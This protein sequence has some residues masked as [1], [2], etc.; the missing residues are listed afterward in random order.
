MCSSHDRP[1]RSHSMQHR[2]PAHEK[3][4]P[5]AVINVLMLLAVSVAVCPS[6]CCTPLP[7]S[8]SSTNTED[9]IIREDA[10]VVG[11]KYVG[12]VVTNWTLVTLHHDT[13]S[14]MDPNVIEAQV[15]GCV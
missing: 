7:T 12:G 11:G 15:R 9:L 2:V 10:D 5:A 6:S 3:T 8:S 13:Q 4:M 1:S 14:C